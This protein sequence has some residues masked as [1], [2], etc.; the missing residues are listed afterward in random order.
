MKKEPLQMTTRDQFNVQLAQSIVHRMLET[1]AQT[2]RNNIATGGTRGTPI[3]DVSITEDVG[4]HRIE[5]RYVVSD[6][7]MV[8]PVTEWTVGGI[9]VRNERDVIAYLTQKQ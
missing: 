6:N 2:I 3:R 1:A 4:R 9:I 5:L 8:N 7:R